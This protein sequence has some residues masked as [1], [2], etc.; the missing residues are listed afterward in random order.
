M[1]ATWNC[2]CGGKKITEK[3]RKLYDAAPRLLETLK[4]VQ[5]ALDN[6]H[7]WSDVVEDVDN[8]IS[9]VEGD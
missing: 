3:K 2:P 7:S 8:A 1:P 5:K 9:Q 6:G 4:K